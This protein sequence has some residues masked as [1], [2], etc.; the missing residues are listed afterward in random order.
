MA[1]YK[2]DNSECDDRLVEEGTLMYDEDC[3]CCPADCLC[4][5]EQHCGD[6]QGPLPHGCYEGCENNG[7][8]KHPDYPKCDGEKCVPAEPCIS[9]RDCKTSS[10]TTVKGADHAWVGDCMDGVCEWI[11]KKCR[12]GCNDLDSDCVIGRW[13]NGAWIEFECMIGGSKTCVT[14]A[15]CVAPDADC[16]KACGCCFNGPYCCAEG[17]WFSIGCQEQE[18]WL[19]K[20]CRYVTPTG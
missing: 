13:C 10:C 6:G 17:S 1:G 2:A 12:Y 4:I 3:A 15:K 18:S 7:D 14:R 9:D 8:C 16:P 20:D 19:D 5:H 11:P